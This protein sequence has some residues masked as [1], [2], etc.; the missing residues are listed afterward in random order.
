MGL[1]GK[2]TCTCVPYVKHDSSTSGK[3]EYRKAIYLFQVT[4]LVVVFSLEQNQFA[5]NACAD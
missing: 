1:G 5:L 3:C 4:L 2:G